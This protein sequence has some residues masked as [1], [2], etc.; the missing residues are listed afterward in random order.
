MSNNKSNHRSKKK[1]SREYVELDVTAF[2]D[3]IKPKSKFNKNKKKHK[4]NGKQNK[5]NSKN[6]NTNK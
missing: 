4:K 2:K 3:I 1:V 6:T 5:S